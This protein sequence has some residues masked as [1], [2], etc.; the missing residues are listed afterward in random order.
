NERRPDVTAV[1]CW[2]ARRAVGCVPP[3]SG[4]LRRTFLATAVAFLAAATSACGRV[5]GRTAWEDAIH[6]QTVAPMKAPDDA[7]YPVPAPPFTPGAFPCSRCHEGGEPAKDALP[8]IPHKLHVARGLEFAD[9]HMADDAESDPK[10]PDRQVCDTCHGDPAKLSK[11]AA[12]YFSAVT[13]ADG[14]TN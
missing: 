3:M 8:A 6:A 4:T 11:G 1:T 5:E 13:S 7:V 12:A 9:C 14:K 10:I 2:P